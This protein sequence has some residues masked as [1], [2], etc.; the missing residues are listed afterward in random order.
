MTTAF[1]V[2][3]EKFSGHNPFIAHNKIISR[4]QNNFFVTYTFTKHKKFTETD[5]KAMQ[6]HLKA[7]S[8]Q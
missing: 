6:G 4:K 8:E 2:F 3:L 5:N 7:Y 1:I